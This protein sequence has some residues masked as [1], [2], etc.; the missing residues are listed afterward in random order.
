MKIPG[1][2]L[3][4]CN[5]FYASCERIFNPELEGKPIGILSNNDGIIV[6]LSNE[7]KALGI[8]R[9]TPGFKIRHLLKRHDIHLFSSN[10]TL[11]GDISSRVMESLA[12]FTPDL[13]IY[14]IDE[15]FLSLAGLEHLDLTA[16]GKKIRKMIKRW[17][18]LPVSIGIGPTKT[19]AK[20]A[21]HVAKRRQELNGVFDITAHPDIEQIMA[22]IDVKKVWGI[23]PQYAKL[24]HRN[25]IHNVLQLSRAP[26]RWVKKRMTIVGLRTVM[27]LNGVPCI[28]L[29]EKA[30]PKKEIVS[31]KSFGTPVTS[32]Q[33]LQE[34]EGY[35]KKESLEKLAKKHNVPL[36][37]IYSLSTF[38]K[39]LSL[40]P[41]ARHTC[42]VCTGTACHVRGAPKI[43]EQ[44]SKKLKIKVGETTEDGNMKLETANCLG[45]CALGPL[46][47]IDKDYH[48]NASALTITKTIEKYK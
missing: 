46:V 10:Y 30:D 32:L 34:A 15:A 4:D 48:G 25:G 17:I 26:H 19:L 39:S 7:L 13:E 14:S 29:E 33:E 23:G 8:T 18:G 43:I 31:S 9:G 38:Y 21:N 44:V 41:P 12:R 20:I 40:V 27:E 45:A 11:Y 5:N 16:Y 37:R 36:S 1:F 28:E 6:A 2:A 22:S 24:L 3:V 42:T 35:L 47:V